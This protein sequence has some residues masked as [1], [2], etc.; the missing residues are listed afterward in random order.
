MQYQDIYEND[1]LSIIMSIRIPHSSQS[2]IFLFD[3]YHVYLKLTSTLK[4]EIDIS[5]PAS[6]CASTMSSTKYYMEDAN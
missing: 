1:H 6:V 3:L 4:P 2:I 5:G